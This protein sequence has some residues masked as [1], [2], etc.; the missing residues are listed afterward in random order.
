MGKKSGCL[1]YIC[2]ALIVS[3]VFLLGF[4]VGRQLEK[5]GIDKQICLDAREYSFLEHEH[6]EAIEANLSLWK[7]ISRLA[8]ERKELREK[9]ALQKA[10]EAKTPKIIWSGDWTDFEKLD[11]LQ[12]K[13]TTCP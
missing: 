5:S 7:G 12:E 11:K 2:F 4:I 9:I 6:D 8:K 3:L 1:S 13:T 10:K